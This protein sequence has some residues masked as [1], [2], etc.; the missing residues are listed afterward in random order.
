MLSDTKPVDLSKSLSFIFY[1]WYSPSTFWPPVQARAQVTCD[2]VFMQWLSLSEGWP[3][4]WQWLGAPGSEWSR[5]DSWY[6][7]ETWPKPTNMRCDDQIDGQEIL[8][9]NCK[10]RNLDWMRLDL[11]VILIDQFPEPREW[12]FRNSRPSKWKIVHLW[13]W[14]GFISVSISTD[15]S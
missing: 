13:F 9:I 11:S 3:P 10:S 12:M 1:T 6:R 2:R 4:G 8:E 7:S 15:D 5:S 14:E